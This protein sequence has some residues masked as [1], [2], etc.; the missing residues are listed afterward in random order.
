MKFENLNEFK[1]VNILFFITNLYKIYS[2]LY[3]VY[4]F[5]IKLL[6]GFTFQEKIVYIRYL[7]KNIYK[8]I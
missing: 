2:I 8:Y 3:K 1:Y 5:C 4:L 7:Y 6:I